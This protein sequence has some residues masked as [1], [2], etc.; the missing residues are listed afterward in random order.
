MMRESLT[1]PGAGGAFRPGRDCPRCGA[2]L[3]RRGE[4]KVCGCG[5][6]EAVRS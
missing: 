3:A 1:P 4:V 2:R 5:H 6:R